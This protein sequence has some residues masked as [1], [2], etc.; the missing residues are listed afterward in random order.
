MTTNSL[1]P[2]LKS[3]LE[4]QC[5]FMADLSRK[6]LDT[7]QGLNALNMR[8][9]QD[10]IAEMTAANQRLLAAGDTAQMLSLTASHPQPGIDKLRDYQQQLSELLAGASRDI[11]STAEAHLPATQCTAAAFADELVR[12]SA[13]ETEKAAQRQRALLGQLQFSIPGNDGAGLPA[14]Q[15]GR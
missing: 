12:K 4:A 6:M 9:A 3:H 11:H 5:Q 15:Q 7:A 13:E 2:A 8:L 14:P 10:L 1:T